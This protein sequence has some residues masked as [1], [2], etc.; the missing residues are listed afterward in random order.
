VSFRSSGSGPGVQAKDGCSVELYRKTPYFG[1][2]EEFRHLFAPGTSVLELGCAT[3][4]LTRRLLEWGARVTAVDNCA[5]MLA[6][7]PAAAS[8]VLSDIESLNLP[9]R[10]DVALLASCFINEP[11]HDVRCAFIETAHRHLREH[12]RLVL[13]C[14]DCAWLG[15]VQPGPL[16]TSGDLVASVEAVSRN[17]DVVH[18]TLRY[19]I[20]ERVWYH[21]FAVATLTESAI[22]ALLCSYGFG[23]FAWSGKSNRWLLASRN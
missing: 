2:L 4:R 10:F 21:S 3:G 19:Q 15:A 11:A 14:H 5:D 12:G 23:S 22:E 9:D 7:V 6:S 20:G 1:E 17:G 8:R 18:M 13:E 16:G